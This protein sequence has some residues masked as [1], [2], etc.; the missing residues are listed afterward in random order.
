MQFRNDTDACL[1]GARE[2]ATLDRIGVDGHFDVLR[3]PTLSTRLSAAGAK[4]HFVPVNHELIG[5]RTKINRLNKHQ[6]SNDFSNDS[7]KKNVS[8]CRKFEELKSSTNILSK[9]ICITKPKHG[10]ILKQQEHNQ[11]L[12]S[13]S[14]DLHSRTKLIRKRP[15]IHSVSERKVL[16]PRLMLCELIPLNIF[17][18]A[19]L[20]KRG[21][22]IK[23]YPVLETAYYSKPTTYQQKS[24][25]IELTRSARSGNVQAVCT[26]IKSGLSAN[27]CNKF[28]ESLI[29]ILAR[30]GKSR[31]AFEMLR[32]LCQLGSQMHLCDDFGRTPLHDACWTVDPCFRSVSLLLDRDIN[33]LRLR[34]KRGSTPFDYVEKRNQ[35]QFIEYLLSKKDVYW[36]PR[37]PT[38]DELPPPLVLLPPHSRMIPDPQDPMSLDLVSAVADGKMNVNEAMML[39]PDERKSYIIKRSFVQKKRKKVG[40]IF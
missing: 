27:P 21:Y 6:R 20:K 36:P 10:H 31:N 15:L 24:Y 32:Q 18:K 17:F 37:D 19:L 22:S 8:Y 40:S 3:S 28:G 23:T 5:S 12:N 30:R 13:S 39:Y 2:A 25:G 33:L 29:H 11:V 35:R 1:N 4:S 7:L 26:L 16:I 38:L 14:K 34:D 9:R